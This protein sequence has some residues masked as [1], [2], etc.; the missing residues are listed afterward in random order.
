MKLLS[1]FALAL[2]LTSVTHCPTAAASEPA[3]SLQRLLTNS[4]CE[5]LPDLLGTWTAT[6]NDLSGTWTIEPL[7]NNKARLLG[8]S[9]NAANPNRPAFDLCIAHLGGSLFFDAVFQSVAP[10][11]KKPLLSEDETLFWA[12]LHLIGRLDL[13]A[14]AMHFRLLSD[15]WLRSEVES[16]RLELKCAQTDEGDYMLTASSRELKQFV[17][18]FA[19]DAE[20]FSYEESF[21]RQ[22]DSQEFA[23][24]PQSSEAGTSNNPGYG[25][26]DARV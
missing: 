15:E 7:P 18:R 17:A 10:D 5:A 19:S 3:I 1:F 13:E 21:E 16:G 4:D 23:T 24:A 12:P 22:T 25:K 2:I 9:E 26:R 20:A 6:G 8:Q 11:G 14:D